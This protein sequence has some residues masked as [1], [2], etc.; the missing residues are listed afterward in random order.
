MAQLQIPLDDSLMAKLKASAQKA[1][2]SLRQFVAEA[3]K[4]AVTK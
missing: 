1:G 4:Q 3:L 2:M